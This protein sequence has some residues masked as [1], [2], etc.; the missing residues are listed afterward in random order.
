MIGKSLATYGLFFEGEPQIQVIP[1]DKNRGE[2][3]VSPHL[4]NLLLEGQNTMNNTS[5]AVSSAPSTSTPAEAPNFADL[6][7]LAAQ[8]ERLSHLADA[9]QRSQPTP[10]ALAIY[11]Q[12]QEVSEAAQIEKIK[13][14]VLEAMHPKKKFSKQAVHFAYYA[15]AAAVGVAVVV[16]VAAVVEAAIGPTE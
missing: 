7:Q 1:R 8:L 13:S 12:Q 2:T 11:K 10:E 9:P 5:P 6:V 16:G 3:V 14:A 15:G 4:H